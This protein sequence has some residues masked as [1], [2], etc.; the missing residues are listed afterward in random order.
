[1]RIWKRFSLVLF[2]LAL[3]ITG[4]GYVAWKMLYPAKYKAQA[5]LLV[6]ARPPMVLFHTVETEGKE[7]Y[8]RYQNT[9]QA[10]VKSQLA[11]NAALRD[12]EVS[13][14]RLVRDQVDPIR[15]L[16]D[17]LNVE[18][19]A[20]SEL[21]EISLTG[22]DPQELAGL[23]NAVKKAYIDEVVNRDIKMRTARFDQLKKL[24]AQYGELLRERREALRK[25]SEPATSDDRRRVTGLERPE[26][27]SLQES[28]WR[29][30]IDLQLDRAR[31]ESRL[32]QGRKAAG[33]A[34]DSGRKETDQ[35]EET[36]AGLIAEEKVIDEEL[37]RMAGE[38][39]KAANQVPNWEELNADIALLEGTYR[40]VCA[41]VE[42]LTVELGAPSRI[43][44]I[45]DAVPPLTRV[46]LT[47][48]G[49]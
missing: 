36:L 41:E 11:L 43:R 26:L 8:K 16:Q 3:I 7:D 35:I 22:E 5:R 40:K 32:A 15:W 2:V 29:Q 24:R 6:A 9:Q 21:M 30:R 48:W 18:F 45:E 14:Y 31:A 19:I 12:R 25:L 17:N 27:L 10:L 42:A 13:R 4:G 33:P 44:T 38:I 47:P 23:V 49:F 46:A 34:T 1:M 28:L 39:Q 37:E 20:E